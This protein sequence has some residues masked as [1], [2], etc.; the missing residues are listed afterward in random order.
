MEQ[1]QQCNYYNETICTGRQG[2]EEEAPLT[3]QED[4]YQIQVLTGARGVMMTVDPGAAVCGG[5]QDPGGPPHLPGA[6]GGHQE[7]RTHRGVR[8]RAS[9][10]LQVT[11]SIVTV[12]CL[13]CNC[14]VC[15]AGR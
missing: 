7:G 10:A 15:T 13:Y 8:A 2:E 1:Q 6:A 12:L 4:C 5:L 14:T 11:S 3:H 9:Q